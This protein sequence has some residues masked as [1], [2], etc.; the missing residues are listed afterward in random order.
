MYDYLITTE[1]RSLSMNLVV[2]NQWWI[3][4]RVGVD[5]G[6]G[7]RS[8]RR[9][10]P[11]P[12]CLSINPIQP[13]IGF[14][15]TRHHSMEGFVGTDP[16]ADF[17]GADGMQGIFHRIKEQTGDTRPFQGELGT[18]DQDKPDVQYQ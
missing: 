15:R 5:I 12:R 1:P 17:R 18:L 13:D 6:I 11:R 14:D 9:Y 2:T 3:F 16:L 7:V 4:I 10:R 8:R